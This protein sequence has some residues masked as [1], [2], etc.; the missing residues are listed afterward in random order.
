MGAVGRLSTKQKIGLGALAAI[1][2]AIV[3]AAVVSIAHHYS[4]KSNSTGGDSTNST[5][6]AGTTAA[7]V[8]Q[9]ANPAVPIYGRDLPSPVDT[10][11]ELHHKSRL[12]RVAD[13]LLEARS[14][15]NDQDR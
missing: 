11:S 9:R 8:A 12:D 4:G 7:T 15:D 1:K 2:V 13:G 10:P 5:Q 6:V 3:T 14:F